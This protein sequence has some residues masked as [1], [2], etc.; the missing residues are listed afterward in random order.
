M[1]DTKV[2]VAKVLA[3]PSAEALIEKLRARH[4]AA[5]FHQ[6]GGC[7]DGSSPICYP[8]DDFIV[9]DRDRDRDLQLGEV[10]GVP[11]YMSSSQY[12]YWEHIQLTIDVIEG[13]GGMSPLENGM[14]VRLLNR[15]RLFTDDEIDQLQQP[16]DSEHHA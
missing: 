13:R 8:Q 11:L 15:S 5:L 7:C 16:D 9:G 1:S 10:A 6:S 3:T 4:G 14:G 2:E 12:R